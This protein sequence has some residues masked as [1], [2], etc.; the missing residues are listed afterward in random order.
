M[1][2]G[3]SIVA[4]SVERTCLRCGK[5]FLPTARGQ[6]YCGRQKERGT[7][8][9]LNGRDQT[10]R[11]VV[12]NKDR[13]R[14]QRRAWARK[15]A[16]DPTYREHLRD[17]HRRKYY[18][19]TR[20]QFDAIKAA[21]GGGC[22]ICGQPRGRF[23]RGCDRDL[24]VDHDH[25]TKLLRGLLCDD[26][27]I[28]LGMFEHSIERLQSAIGYL[29]RHERGESPGMAVVGRAAVTD[30]AHERMVKARKNDQ[31][32]RRKRAVSPER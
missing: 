6:K 12:E 14:D 16:E 9:W 32:R 17:R 8:S 2:P 10:K 22:A 21:Q 5:A 23:L 15:R 28:G 4:W 31:A 26:C 3:A 1:V 24:A 11:F 29:Q 19:I 30:E 7:C 20:E 25:A 13:C 27:N 18:G